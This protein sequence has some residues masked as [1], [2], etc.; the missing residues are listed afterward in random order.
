M[1][2]VKV[3]STHLIDVTVRPE[4]LVSLTLLLGY[5]LIERPCKW[6][7]TELTGSGWPTN[8]EWGIT[9]LTRSGWNY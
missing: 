5:S 8:N 7:I 4:A 9:E 2:Y 1:I 3:Y 6:G